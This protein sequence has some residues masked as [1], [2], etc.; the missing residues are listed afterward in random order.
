MIGNIRLSEAC[1]L[2]DHIDVLFLLDTLAHLLLSSFL[3][4]ILKKPIAIGF[5]GN[6]HNN[7]CDFIYLYIEKTAY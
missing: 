6:T 1:N 2:D 7:E 4:H 3:K 5:N